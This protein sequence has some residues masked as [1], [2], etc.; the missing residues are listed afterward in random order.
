MKKNI[1]TVPALTKYGNMKSIVL[2]SGGSGGDSMTLAK[3]RQPDLQDSFTTSPDAGDNPD[4]INDIS[5]NPT[6]NDPI[7][8]VQD[9]RK[10]A[11]MT[12]LDDAADPGSP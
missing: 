12:N 10:D 4:T 11:P 6:N 9:T 3:D 5:R 8:A 7:S 1:Y 2:G